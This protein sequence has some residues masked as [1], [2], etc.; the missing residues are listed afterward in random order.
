MWVLQGS[1]L[2]PCLLLINVNE[3]P[4]VVFD[5]TVNLYAD[6]I[7]IYSVCKEPTVVAARLNNGLNRIAGW[8]KTNKLK[9]LTVKK[10]Q[11][12]TMGGRGLRHKLEDMN[13]ELWGV[14]I[15]KNEQVKCL[16]VIIDKELKWQPH[17]KE[18]LRKTLAALAS[19]R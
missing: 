14:C 6:D 12:M 18:V 16:S 2:G 13:V 11:Q 7:T 17:V 8:V 3:L 5:C 15:H 10:T 9:V 4:A 19:I 1:I